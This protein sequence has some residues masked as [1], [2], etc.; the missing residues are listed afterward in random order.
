MNQKG[1][2]F[3]GSLIFLAMSLGFMVLA[4]EIQKSGNI[5]IKAA[6]GFDGAIDL[7]KLQRFESCE[8]YL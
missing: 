3:V 6:R 1:N 7:S 2:I 5:Q 4:P 8:L